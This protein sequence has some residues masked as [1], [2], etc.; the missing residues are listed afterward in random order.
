MSPNTLQKKYLAR[1]RRPNT[2]AAHPPAAAAP[3]ADQVQHR[4][5]PDG[6]EGKTNSSSI[7]HR[8][9]KLTLFKPGF[10][11]ETEYQL[12]QAFKRPVR[13]YKED[14]PFYPWLPRKTGKW[15]GIAPPHPPAGGG[16]SPP[17][18]PPTSQNTPPPP[19]W[20]RQGG[21]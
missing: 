13:K 10:E 3:G 6:L 19:S 4:Q 18:T 8:T 11:Q 17:R 14:S 12:A 16:Q 2:P 1:A 9:V 21:G 20:V 15:G 7:S 5:A